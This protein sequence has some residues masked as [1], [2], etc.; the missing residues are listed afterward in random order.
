V[1]RAHRFLTFMFM[2]DLFMN[3]LDTVYPITLFVNHVAPDNP[4]ACK[5]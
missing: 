1:P 5:L 4:G 3:D 2:N